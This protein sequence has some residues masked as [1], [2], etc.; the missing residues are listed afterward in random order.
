MS[1]APGPRQ[2]LDSSRRR[3]GKAWPPRR[4]RA[5]AFPETQGWIGLQVVGEGMAR[6]ECGLRDSR[7]PGEAGRREGRSLCLPNSAKGCF[8]AFRPG[9]GARGPCRGAAVRKQK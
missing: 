2:T 1:C 6:Q 8:W 4:K 3:H 5:A 9:S 7:A